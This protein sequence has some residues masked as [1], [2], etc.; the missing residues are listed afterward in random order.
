[1]DT[2][3]NSAVPSFRINE[4]EGPLDLLLFLIKKDEINVYD[5]P[6]AEITEQYLQYLSAAAE[7]DLEDVTEFHAMAATLLYIKSRMLLPVEIDIS[8]DDENEDPRQELVDKL[9]EYQKF[10]KL[11]E[12]MEEK[13][14]QAEWSIERK[15][16]QQPLPFAEDELWEKIDVWDLLK[17]FS[18]LMSHLSGEG[19]ERIIDLY[20]EVSVNEKITL[21]NELLENRGECNFMDLVVRKGSV[22]DFVCAFLAILEAVKIRIVLVFQNRMFGD[23]LIRPRPSKVLDNGV[24]VGERNSPY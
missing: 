18:A 13:E 17:T 4:F 12:L 2:L 1:M 23:I 16:L 24:T 9:I 6:I 7:L 11:S 21:I 19:I 3:H 5:I 15:K 10:K 14:R 20:E 8:S 22:M